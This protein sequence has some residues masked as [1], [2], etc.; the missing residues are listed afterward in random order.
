[1]Y[2]ILKKVQ[3]RKIEDCHVDSLSF[4]L[5]HIYFL[6][7]QYIVAYFVTGGII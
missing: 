4:L 5:L 3:D 2:S 6:A 7:I 1:M